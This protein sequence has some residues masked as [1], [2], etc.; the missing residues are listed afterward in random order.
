MM[1]DHAHC[2]PYVKRGKLTWF[3]SHTRTSY[4]LLS[5]LD[6]AVVSLLAGES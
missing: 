3:E 4:D 6:V 5:L 2:F 1:L